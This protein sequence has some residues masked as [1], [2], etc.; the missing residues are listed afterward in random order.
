LLVTWVGCG[1]PSDRPVVDASLPEPEPTS[2][3]EAAA[4]RESAVATDPFA[5]PIP[6]DVA[7][8]LAGTDRRVIPLRL[9]P[10]GEVFGRV[11]GTNE[12]RAHLAKG[13]A[14]R[15]IV[16]EADSKSVRVRAFVAAEDFPVH[17]NRVSVFGGLAVPTHDADLRV[18][19]V[20]ADEIE[21]A[22]DLPE[23]V[24]RS[25]GQRVTGA[26]PCSVLSIAP[27]PFDPFENLFG[28]PTGFA[29][30]R[31]PKIVLSREAR[32]GADATLAP[33][34]DTPRDVAITGQ[35][36]Q[37]YRIAWLVEGVIVFGWVDATN[38]DLGTPKPDPPLKIGLG[39]VGTRGPCCEH[40][41]ICPDEV[42][43][44]A[45]SPGVKDGTVAMLASGTRIPVPRSIGDSFAVALSGTNLES[46]NLFV[47]KARVAHCRD[48][49]LR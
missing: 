36:G 4:A 37:R 1:A 31:G 17:P 16:V 21:L 45:R 5:A 7:C 33:S 11:Q 40:V 43:L 38:L 29:R 25:S 49:V 6:A 15:G 26:L 41:F 19:D 46:G 10:G 44:V 42:P 22:L 23:V 12:I 8:A 35:E 34:A 24:G 9:D 13:S 39:D 14:S 32:G 3:R 2:R 20:R 48:L 28:A 30:L 27:E 18:V 47:D